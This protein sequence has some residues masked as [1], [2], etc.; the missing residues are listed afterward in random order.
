MHA[1]S[2]YGAQTIYD[3][4]AKGAEALQGHASA[5]GQ[6][7]RVARS[8]A[9]VAADCRVIV[10]ML[11]NTSHVL[12]VYTNDKTGIFSAFPAADS[13]ASHP[14]AK[15]A[16]SPH[17][18]PSASSL[19]SSSS[20]P[21]F[22]DSSTI[23]P[24]TSR[25]LAELASA[26]RCHMLDAP[27]SGG[28]N[29]AEQGT[30]TFMVGASASAFHAAQPYLQLMGRN[31]VHCGEAGTGQSAK[32]CNNLALAIQMA[33]VAEA[34]TL[35]Q[36]LGLD[37]HKLAAIMNTSTGR[38]WS[39]DTYHPVPGVMPNVPSS[40]EYAGG[41]GSALMMK[42]LG[43][44]LE[45]GRGVG[46]RAEMGEKVLALYERV[47]EKGWAGKDFSVLYQLMKEEADGS[48]AAPSATAH[49]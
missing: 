4:I 12:D 31:V 18:S 40:R 8:P 29:G 28:I 19:S 30:L 15:A 16:H 46:V 2:S 47:K 36:R 11:P 25:H 17:P 32:I 37:V 27:V 7:V 22:I 34:C 42:D 44:A 10:T 43:L 49:K 1:L 13:S 21:L 41:F 3:V 9:D 35:A 33:S 48:A 20:T 6:A 39:S 26:R 5:A 45:A 38:C 24:A 23:D 14:S